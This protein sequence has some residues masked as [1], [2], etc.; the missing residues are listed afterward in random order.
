MP[1]VAELEMT[2]EAGET[3]ENWWFHGFK[4]AEVSGTFAFVTLCP[5]RRGLPPRL[6][7]A[8]GL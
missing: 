7:L 1:K 4:S 2:T 5:G 3:G 8:A 6:R